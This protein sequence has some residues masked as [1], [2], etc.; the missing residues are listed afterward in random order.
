MSLFV[1]LVGWLF[2]SICACVFSGTFRHIFVLINTFGDRVVLF[3]H[4]VG[5]W[6]SIYLTL[7]G[8]YSVFLM[9]GGTLRLNLL[10]LG[11]T[12]GTLGVHFGVFLRLWGRTLDPF[13]DFSAKGTKKNRKRELERMHFQW[14]FEFFQKL[15]KYVSTA[16]ARTD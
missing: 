8:K 16:P 4:F 13:C 11:L 9:L 5:P 6:G 12:V 15:D 3:L 2:V 1:S 14:N 7:G 10:I